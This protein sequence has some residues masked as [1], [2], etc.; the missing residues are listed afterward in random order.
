M[1]DKKINN[2]SYVVKDWAGNTMN[3]ESE[4]YDSFDDAAEAID[5]QIERELL[6]NGIDV[7]KTYGLELEYPA[8]DDVLDKIKGEYAGEYWIEP[9]HVDLD[10][11][12][13]G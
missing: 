11:I 10:S 4:T 13:A 2:G 5:R 8:F 6:E 7:N 12:I 9:S 3:W 1:R